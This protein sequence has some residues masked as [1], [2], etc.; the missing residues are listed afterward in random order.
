MT[1]C[2]PFLACATMLLDGNAL[3]SPATL[4]GRHDVL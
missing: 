4:G 3:Y 2:V 1:P